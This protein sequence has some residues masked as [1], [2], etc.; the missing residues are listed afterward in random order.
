LCDAVVMLVGRDDSGLAEIRGVSIVRGL[1]SAQALFDGLP[2]AVTELH[3][4]R[5]AQTDADRAAILADLGTITTGRRR[6]PPAARE[7]GE[8]PVSQPQMQIVAT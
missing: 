7:R 2:P 8:E 5:L 4:H 6:C 1:A 3:A